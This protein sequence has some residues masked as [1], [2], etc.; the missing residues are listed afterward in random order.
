MK[1][2]TVRFLFFILFSFSACQSL[3]CL[4]STKLL[5]RDLTEI[6]GD[7]RISDSQWSI[8]IFSLD[9]NKVLFE[10]NPRKLSIPASNNKI[11]TAV[12]ALLQLGPD[13]RFKTQFFADGSIENGVLKGS[14]IITGLGDPSSSSR[15]GSKD[16]FEA[17]RN[18]AWKLKEHGIRAID[19]KI[20]GDG[21]AF[22][23]IPYGQGWAWD[24]LTEG[25]AAPI[26][27]LQ[28]NENLITLEIA[29]GLEIGSFAKSST[30]PL[31]YPPVD[32]KIRTEAS[33]AVSITI[34][35]DRATE[36]L[37]IRGVVPYKNAL[38]TRS[39]A[40]QFPIRYYLSALK[41]ILTEEG[42][43]TTHCI[44]EESRAI[45]PRSSTPLW[46]HSSAP[47]SDLLAPNL[48]LSLNLLSETLLRTMGL[49]LRGEGTYRKG[50]EVVEE[51]L[52]EMGVPPTGYFYADA[53]GLS[54]LNL[55]TSEMM[56]HILTY[57]YQ[58]RHFPIF[59][60]SLSL[61]GVDGTLK[62]RMIG[63]RAENNVHAK[64]GTLSH[65][66]AISGY[67]KTVDG[68]ML[69]FSVIANNFLGSKELA[70]NLQDKALIR[71]ADF[72]RKASNRHSFPKRPNQSAI[73]RK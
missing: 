65:V 7:S 19:G 41:Q 69:A 54:R 66:S 18:W 30:K 43:D 62:S 46:I 27:A 61:A 15:I 29:P 4:D 16:P 52:A 59:Y 28:F 71:L 37:R 1:S 22:E 34:E 73:E 11:L 72:S 39:V 2:L 9:K 5:H 6:F 42:I 35:Q 58:Q 40:A 49:E 64:T 44:I 32:S 63:T 17:F 12:A 57:M 26:S 13:Y 23:E 33:G 55:V 8:T 3:F 60:S 10:K 21:S 53:S 68:E 67:V 70:E 47:L 51:T 24:D 36:T 31:N 48:K 56:T 50:K 14:L 25:Y 20:I 45:H 38:L